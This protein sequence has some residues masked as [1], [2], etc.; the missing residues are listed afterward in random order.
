[1][2]GEITGYQFT[3]G[4]AFTPSKIRY[5]DENSKERLFEFDDRGQSNLFGLVDKFS[6]K[7]SPNITPEEVVSLRSEFSQTF[8]PTNAGIT[9]NYYAGFSFLLE[10]YQSD[11]SDAGKDIT[12]KEIALM[13]KAFEKWCKQ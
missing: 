12:P 1:M 7:E 9:N 5:K 8:V 10:T 4:S 2:S 13:F 6:T 11:A 3:K